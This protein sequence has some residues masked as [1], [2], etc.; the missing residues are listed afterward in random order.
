[1]AAGC[2][3]AAEHNKNLRLPAVSKKYM[4]WEKDRQCKIIQWALTERHLYNT[5]LI[6]VVTVG[7]VYIP[8][9]NF[10]VTAEVFVTIT[11]I[12]LMN[13]Y[14]CSN[15]RVIQNLDWHD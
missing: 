12:L 1:M 13:Q 2:G 15:S 10:S 7:E 14:F 3:S 5:G 4:S 6:L 8:S 9:L 11:S